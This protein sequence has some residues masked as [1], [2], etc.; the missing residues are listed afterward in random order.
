M[1]IGW[2]RVDAG[3]RQASDRQTRSIR[4][5]TLGHALRYISEKEIG[6]VNQKDQ[7]EAL[8]ADGDAPSAG[9]RRTASAYPL[10]I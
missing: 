4:I 1:G 7:K 9:Q 8:S 2:K 3:S 10:K 5:G 6:S